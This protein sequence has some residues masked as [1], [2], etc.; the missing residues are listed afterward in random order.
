LLQLGA[1]VRE[2]APGLAAASGA[3]KEVDAHA[4]MVGGEVES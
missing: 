2:A 4:A 1:D 3:E